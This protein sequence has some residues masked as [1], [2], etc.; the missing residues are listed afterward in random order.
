M[1]EFL[2]TT[3]LDKLKSSAYKLFATPRQREIAATV[4]K[5]LEAHEARRKRSTNENQLQS[6]HEPSD[7][8]RRQ[9]PLDLTSAERL[10]TQEFEFTTVKISTK[11]EAA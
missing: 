7:L 5:Y 10:R 4:T 6:N 3:L 2:S 11:M 9:E 8:T 1:D